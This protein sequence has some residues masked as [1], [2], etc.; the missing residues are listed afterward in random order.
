MLVSLICSPIDFSEEELVSCWAN[1]MTALE[2]LQHLQLLDV[3]CS[4]AVVQT[5][6]KKVGT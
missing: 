1:F 2:Q 5:I 4:S 3:L 6:H